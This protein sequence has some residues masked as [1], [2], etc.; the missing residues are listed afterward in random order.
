MPPDNLLSAVKCGT[1]AR[2]PARRIH[3][4]AAAEWVVNAQD[5]HS[6][7]SLRGKFSKALG[8]RT[9][10]CRRAGTD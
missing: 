5:E 1:A 7:R 10:A 3:E 2:L 9:L 6:A 8:A 4:G